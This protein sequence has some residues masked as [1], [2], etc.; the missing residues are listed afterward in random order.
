MNPRLGLPSVVRGRGRGRDHG[1]GR[2]RLTA[3]PS[4]RANLDVIAY[5]NAIWNRTE[6][7]P[8]P[9]R[10]HVQHV[11]NLL[12]VLHERGIHVDRRGQPHNRC[13]RRGARRACGC[14]G[15]RGRSAHRV[16]VS[17]AVETTVARGPVG[18]DV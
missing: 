7:V 13:T 15:G 8:V 2:G 18:D 4:Q 17:A 6:A 11:W 9:T 16:G 5:R 10:L 12:V 1:R 14:H 3:L